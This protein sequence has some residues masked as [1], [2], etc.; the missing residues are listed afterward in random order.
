[1]FTFSLQRLRVPY[2]IR[3]VFVRA[4]V[5]GVCAF[6][7][8]GVFSAVAPEFLSAQLHVHSPAVSGVL[9]FL[10]MG[11]SAFGQTLVDR[12]GKDRAFFT[13]CAIMLVGLALLAACILAHSL[14]A[15]FLSAA[16][17]GVG[18]GIVMGF[19]LANINERI[20]ERRGEVTS[21]YFVLIYA[22]LALPVVA[23]GFAAVPL[24]LP[25]AGLLFCGVVGLTVAS[26][27]TADF[28]GARAQ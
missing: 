16:A 22:G 26:V 27:M 21:A 19:G 15:I 2:E 8:S 1:R 12:L 14:T 28:R 5:A 6:A 10:L 25:V 20:T 23:V 17:A 7:V 3:G 24:G 9:V 11:S 4:A 13:G 18:Q